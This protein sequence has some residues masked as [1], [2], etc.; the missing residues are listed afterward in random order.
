MI[1]TK[2][3]ATNFDN[4]IENTGSFESLMYKTKYFRWYYSTACSKY[5]KWS[6]KKYNHCC[7]FE[8]TK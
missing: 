2:E 7:T 1:Y 8:T 6:A 5:C 3:E 4:D